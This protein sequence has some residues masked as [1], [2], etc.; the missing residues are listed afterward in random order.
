MID[1]EFLA[2]LERR[3]ALRDTWTLEGLLDQSGGASG[4]A[5]VVVDLVKGFCLQGPLANDSVASLVEPTVEFLKR[6]R[7]HGIT[8][9]FFPCDAHQSDSQE[10]A[11]FPP[12]CIAGS[13][14]SELMEELTSLDFSDLFQRI[15]KRSVSS[16]IGTELAETI[17]SDETR[18]VICM[19]DCTDL[20]LYHLAVGLRFFA[21]HNHL[22]WDI[23]V[24]QNL[25]ATY[26]VSVAVAEELKILPHPGE[27][28]NALFLYHLELNGVRVVRS[29]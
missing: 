16:L 20:C 23:V 17:A 4:C 14:E 28:M 3:E 10:F 13:R 21:N 6:A 15:D 12:H 24:P 1:Q 9:Y 7:S 25:V 11:A 29:L 2:W 8:R 19:G 22:K 18:T 26:D 27:M 5:V